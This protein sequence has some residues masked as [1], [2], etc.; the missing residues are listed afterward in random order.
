MGATV[1]V[2]IIGRRKL[3]WGHVGDSRL[4][5]MRGG[6]MRQITKDHSFLQDFID[7]GELSER[8]ALSHPMAHVL[9]Q[10]VGCLSEGADFGSLDIASGD[11]ILLSTDGLYRTVAEKQTGSII[12]SSGDV[13][14]SVGD[15]L[16]LAADLHAPDDTTVI[17]AHV[18]DT[19]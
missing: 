16:S 2:A 8:E 7:N 13:S 12:S 3:W 17:L 11:F 5:L 19:A 9:D 18:Y 4:Y 15:L 6:Q 1:T 10:C 14:R